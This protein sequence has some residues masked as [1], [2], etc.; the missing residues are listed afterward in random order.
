L[1]VLAPRGQSD[2]PQAAGERLDRGPV[3]HAYRRRLLEQEAG[4]GGVR[5]V[6]NGQLSVGERVDITRD[7]RHVRRVRITEI[8]WRK[9]MFA[10]ARAGEHVLLQLEAIS[11]EEVLEDDILSR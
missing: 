6:L 11:R 1:E 4:N 10:E 2:G 7:G 3:H 8:S 9:K 5:F